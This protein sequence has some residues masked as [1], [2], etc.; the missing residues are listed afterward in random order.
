MSRVDVLMINP[1]WLSKDDNIWHGIKSAMPPL[2]L[3]SV[4]AFVERAGHNVAVIDVHVEKC[5]ERE[6]RARVR[7]AQPNVVGLSVMT[8]TANAA[9]Q[10]ARLVKEECPTA[11]V[12]FGGVHPEALPAETL[13]NSAVDCVVRGDGE[14]PFLQIC[15]GVPLPKVLGVSYREGDVV[16][17]NPGAQVE[18]DLDKYPMPAYHLVPMDK[19]YPAIGAYKRLP[20]INMVMTRGCPG[21]CNFCNSANTTLR[22]RSA[23]RVFE[24]VKFLHDNYGIREIQFYDDTFTVFRK[25]VHRFCELMTESK[26]D[27]SWACFVRADCFSEK[28]AIAMKSAG[29]HQIL[30]GIES[31]DEKVLELIGKPIDKKKNQLCIDIGKK[32]G[33]DTRAAF[34]FGSRGE[35]LDSMKRTLEY[36]LELNP[37][38]ALFNVS[39]PYPGTGL[40]K[41]AQ[42]NGH[43]VSEEWSEF[44]L[45]TFLMDLPT[46]DTKD[47]IEF[48]GHAHRKFYMRPSAIRRRLSRIRSPN[49]VKDL[50]SAF[51]FIVLRHKLGVRGSVRQDWIGYKKEDF[52]DLQVVDGTAPRLT[53]EVRRDIEHEMPSQQL[54]KRAS[55]G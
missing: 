20:A 24:E 41:W 47:L 22:T 4:A 49:H 18:M 19:Y 46:L 55:A 2:G 17:H 9:H 5:S 48:H 25:N 13:C 11:I 26:M 31:A 52:F 54:T 7:T 39:T 23:D 34:I 1:P 15:N 21:K 3:L 53:F 29:C 16:N 50:I 32:V 35:T 27:I 28:M 36:S 14:E 8:A 40:F 37:D 43:L 45:S 42:D 44:E 12:V 38:L 10:I 30:I 6:L 33:I 51:W